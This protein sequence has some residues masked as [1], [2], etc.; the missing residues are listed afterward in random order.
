MEELTNNKA[1]IMNAAS[2]AGYPMTKWSGT[3][4]A[5]I[6]HLA[7]VPF[8][9]ELGLKFS[10]GNPQLA[11]VRP[12]Q[13]PR[14][15]QPLRPL[16]LQQPHQPQQQQQQQQQQ[17]PQQPQQQGVSNK[18]NNVDVEVVVRG[19]LEKFFEQHGLKVLSGSVKASEQ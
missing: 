9:A 2:L 7:D 15:L 18:E 19:V 4:G 10:G 14:P 5:I 12:L 17:Q 6:Q 11:P 3:K 13:P 1:A 16:Q 8:L